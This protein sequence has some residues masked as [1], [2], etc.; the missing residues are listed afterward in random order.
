MTIEQELEFINSIVDDFKQRYPNFE[1]TLILNSYKM[2]GQQHVNK[3]LN[4][5]RVGKEKFPD[6]VAGYDM[7]NEEEY[8]PGIEKFMPSILGA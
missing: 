4:H 2:L 8:T 7:V 1:M 6:L 5:C 3:V